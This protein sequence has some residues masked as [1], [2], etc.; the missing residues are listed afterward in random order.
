MRSRSQEPYS[1]KDSRAFQSPTLSK[2]TRD[3]VMVCSSTLRASPVHH[4]TK[5]CLPRWVKP[6][7]KDKR[8]ACHS[9]QSRI[10]FMTHLLGRTL[11][12]VT[13]VKLTL[14]GVA[15][16]HFPFAHSVEPPRSKPCIFR[17]TTV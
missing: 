5:R 3:W 7:A 11:T 12:A 14:G 6:R 13:S 1:A 17:E 10:A 4:W 15:V 16:H 2:A 8:M 9:G